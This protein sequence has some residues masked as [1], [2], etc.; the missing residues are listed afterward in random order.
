MLRAWFEVS[1]SVPRGSWAHCATLTLHIGSTPLSTCVYVPGGAAP[2]HSH[3]AR[4]G[5][6]GVGDTQAA[7]NGVP[8]T[9]P[10]PPAGTQ[11]LARGGAQHH[12]RPARPGPCPSRSLSPPPHPLLPPQHLPPPR[13]QF[14]LLSPPLPTPLLPPQPQPL[15]PACSPGP[16]PPAPPPSPAALASPFVP[17]PSVPIRPVALY[18]VS[19]DSPRTPGSPEASSFVSAPR[20]PS[21]APRAPH[22]PRRPRRG[23]A[24]LALLARC[25]SATASRGAALR[26]LFILWRPACAPARCYR[27]PAG[28]GAGTRAARTRRAS[29]PGPQ[30]GA[31]WRPC[32][33]DRPLQGRGLRAAGL[34]PA[35]GGPAPGALRAAG[36]RLGPRRV[37]WTDCGQQ[38]WRRA[39]DFASCR[40]NISDLCWENS[41]RLP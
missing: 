29:P 35:L 30:R 18:I 1:L 6:A 24:E 41:A 26:R 3:T 28:A 32:P 10:S 2:P 8:R 19:R 27:H 16:V 31:A 15:P 23:P 22:S 38:G 40:T 21:A 39:L 33:S 25:G 12:P 5:P 17:P 36:W 20:P 11:T 13:P 34:P 37:A 7:L 9:G 14:P 4:V